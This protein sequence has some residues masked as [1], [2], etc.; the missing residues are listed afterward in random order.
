MRR[1]NKLSEVYINIF[2]PIP[3]FIVNRNG[4]KLLS[5][6]GSYNGLKGV[7]VP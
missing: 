6:K 3:L 7:P 4:L 2:L 5:S 1:C